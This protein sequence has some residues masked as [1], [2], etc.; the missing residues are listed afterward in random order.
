VKHRTSI[1]TILLGFGFA[2]ALLGQPTFTK[3]EASRAYTAAFAHLRFQRSCA[4]DIGRARAATLA[5]YCR[6]VSGATHPPCSVGNSCALMIDH[7]QY[8][9]RG[10]NSW[11]PCAEDLTSR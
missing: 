6:Y 1:A 11:L 7:I 9:C 2:T 5:R 10:S 3:H 8:M 4:A